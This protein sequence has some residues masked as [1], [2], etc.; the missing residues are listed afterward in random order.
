MTEIVPYSEAVALLKQELGKRKNKIAQSLPPDLMD[1]ARYLQLA[2]TCCE[3][4]PALMECTT[5]S[6]IGGIVESAQLGLPID[7]SLGYAY[8]VPFFDRKRNVRRAV[9][10]PGYKGLM[11]LA[12][13]SAQVAHI[14]ADVVRKGDQ[15][16]EDRGDQPRLVHTPPPLEERTPAYLEDVNIVG[17]YACAKLTNGTTCHVLMSRAE[18]EAI[19]SRSPARNVGPWVTDY[20]AMAKKTPIRQLAKFLPLSP[21]DQRQI[22]RDE[23]IDAGLSPPRSRVEEDEEGPTTFTLDAVPFD[24]ARP[25]KA[26]AAFEIRPSQ[27]HAAQ[28]FQEAVQEHLERDVVES[29]QELDLDV[30]GPVDPVTLEYLVEA[31]KARG[32]CEEELAEHLD[33]TYGVREPWGL[34]QADAVQALRELKG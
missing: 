25:E 15:I 19:R 2:Q 12:R 8:L 9:F 30:D 7:N 16:V 31:S 34:S 5:L 14:W 18:I 24:E 23:Q 17:A 1:P 10:I 28:A 33:K 20:P 32:W 22:A 13:R 3:K 6:L 26:A 4:T 21:D 27:E 29:A 11:E